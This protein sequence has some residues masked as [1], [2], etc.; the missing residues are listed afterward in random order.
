MEKQKSLLGSSNTKVADMIEIGKIIK[1]RRKELG[2]TQTYI[3]QYMGVSPR[4]IGDI[5]RGKKTVAIQT[6]L[7]YAT[8]L[9][10]DFTMSIRGK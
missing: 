7:N 10:I 2:Y 6:I 4:L 1:R 9:G 3:A 8:G 5:E